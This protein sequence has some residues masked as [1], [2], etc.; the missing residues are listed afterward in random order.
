MEPAGGGDGGAGSSAAGAAGPGKNIQLKVG[1]LGD[2]AVGKTSLMVKY[3]ENKFDEDYIQT[4]GINFMEKIISLRDRTV[5]FTIF[6]LG[7]ES[8][9]HSMIPLVCADASA[10]L[11]MFDLTR[12]STL[13][14]VKEWYRQARG[15]N[16]A[17][18]PF[19]VGTKFDS[20]ASLPQDKQE[21]TINHARKFAKAMKSPLVFTSASHSINV[22][23]LFKIVLSKRFNLKLTIEQLS[24]PG[25]PILEY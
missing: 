23:K 2:S 3:V 18:I 13:Q 7:G 16:Q 8:E 9:F 24:N 5:T 22:Q 1:M 12:R 25:E 20:F 17:F 4:L 15:L 6:D 21:D 11:F 14:S 10:I 19:L